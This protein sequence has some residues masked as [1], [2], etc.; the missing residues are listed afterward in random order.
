MVP[1]ILVVDDEKDIPDLISIQFYKEIEAGIF[2]F[3]F[4][5]HGAEALELLKKTHIDM[6]IT[7]IIMPNIDGLKLLERISD[8]YPKVKTVVVSAYGDIKNIRVAMNCGAFDF[9]VKPLQMSDLFI[10]INKTLAAIQKEKEIEAQLLQSAKLA[11]LGELAT[12][13]AHELNQPLG[14]ISLNTE[15]TAEEVDNGNYGNV[16]ETLAMTVKQ[17]K[18]AI[19]IINHLRNFGRKTSRGEYKKTTLNQ[20]IADTLLLFERQ[21]KLDNVEVIQKLSMDLPEVFCHPIQLEQVF[22]NLLNNAKDALKEST[23]KKIYIRTFQQDSTNIVELEDTGAGI[24]QKYL[25]SIFTPFFT[26]KDMGNGTGLGLSIS[27]AII[28]EHK[29]QISVQSKVGDGTLFRIELPIATEP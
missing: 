10:T 26:T 22:T 8:L 17:V 12:S 20:V 21:F 5:S 28:Q 15:I 3:L 13:V 2:K 25:N 18:K 11:S 4:A 14:V 7:D 24:P 16:P 19:S 27:Y 6:V 23:E 9:L 1:I 29:G